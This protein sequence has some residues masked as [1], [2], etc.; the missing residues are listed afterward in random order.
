MVYD[1]EVAHKCAACAR[2][3]CKYYF[4]A[5]VPTLRCLPYHAGANSYRSVF[6]RTRNEGSGRSSFIAM[7]KFS[8][9][10]DVLSEDPNSSIEIPH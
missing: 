1:H 9:S 8:A 2:L 5:V 4:L 3:E 10:G 7:P 6:V